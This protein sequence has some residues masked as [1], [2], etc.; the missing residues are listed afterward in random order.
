MIPEGIVVGSDTPEPEGAPPAIRVKSLVKAYDPD[1]D[2][3]AISRIVEAKI[4]D[5]DAKVFEGSAR[6]HKWLSRNRKHYR[7]AA[8]FFADK[9]V[10]KR[11]RESV[12]SSKIKDLTTQLREN[13]LAGY[14][15][16]E[17]ASGSTAKL[18][19]MSDTI[20]PGM[21][22]PQ[23]KQMTLFD[24]LES[25]RKCFEAATRNPLGKRICKIVGQFVISRGVRGSINDPEYQE[26]WDNFWREN[27]MRLRIKDILRELIIYG[28][29]FL[30]YFNMRDGLVLRSLDPS[31][32]WEI[33]TD[34]EDIEQ[35]KYYH[36][37]FVTTNQLIVAFP[38]GST[39]PASK[40]VIRQIPAADIDHFKINATSHEKRG[41][42]ELFAI[43]AGLVRFR[44]F[45]ND[46]I[47]L[48]KMRAMFALDVAVDGDGAALADAEQ[49]FETPPGSGSVL[50]HNSKVAVEF[51]NANN[52]A[53]EAKTDAEMLLKLIAVGAGVSEQFLGVSYA[54]SRASALIQT[55]PDVKN[56]EEYREI[57]EEILLSASRR[58]FKADGLEEPDHDMEFT[59]P[60]LASEDRSAKVK[61]IALAEA[62]DYFSKERAA[63]MVA[64]EFDVTNFNYEQEQEAIQEERALDPVMAQGFQQQQKV[65]PDPIELAKVEAALKPVT[66]TQGGGK[67]SK[68][69]KAKGGEKKTVMYAGAQ[70]GFPSDIGGRGLPGTRRQL[71][72]GKF[73]RGS[74]KTNIKKNRTSN[75]PRMNEGETEPVY[76]NRRGWTDRARAASLIE[77]KRRRAARLMRIAEEAR[78]EASKLSETSE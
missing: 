30:R 17:M 47:V 41:R 31:T 5:I 3:D 74:E 32:I 8:Q 19:Q 11:I 68:G 76:S 59:F 66:V 75:A 63:T 10:R 58:V 60:S 22:S 37:Q 49:K 26:A 43:L 38:P 18:F 55:E 54:N 70:A 62:M 51:K 7:S 33:V 73:T 4:V 12:D 56:F 67:G 40:L 16:D 42:S 69:A 48:N 72:R 25:H 20:L 9:D 23:A 44:D 46:R 13:Y 39:P 64:R 45:V 1:K 15:P 27:R 65:A 6:T 50:I 29:I 53:N 78:T 2:L 14:Y 34:E 24:V 52:N 28:E 57:V 77:R 21:M 36:Q 35:V 71:Q 61:D